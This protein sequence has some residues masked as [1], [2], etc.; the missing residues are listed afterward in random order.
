MRCASVGIR[1]ISIRNAPPGD[2]RRRCQSQWAGEN[3]RVTY[4][5]RVPDFPER[6]RGLGPLPQTATSAIWVA[7]REQFKDIRIGEPR[8]RSRRRTRSWLNTGRWGS[9]SRSASYQFV[10]RALIEN[11]QSEYKHLA[12]II[13]D[14]RCVGLI[15]WANIE[16]RTQNRVAWKSFLSPAEA[17]HAEAGG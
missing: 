12:A 4:F 5:K 6:F 16:D 10:A 1:V 9:C 3:R 11:R 17:I 8:R 15:D 7:M 2:A 13:N 14:A